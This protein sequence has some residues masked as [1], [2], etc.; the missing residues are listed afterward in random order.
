MQFLFISAPLDS[1][2]VNTMPAQWKDERV[3]KVLMEMDKRLILNHM[4][5]QLNHNE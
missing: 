4:K 2:G 5:R 1:K 3:I